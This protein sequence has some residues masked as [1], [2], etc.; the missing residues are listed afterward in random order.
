MKLRQKPAIVKG[1]VSTT[2]VQDPTKHLLRTA[3]FWVITQRI[4]AIP[5]RYIGTTCRSH[6]KGSGIQKKSKHLLLL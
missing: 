2:I 1:A 6:L 4:V 5:Y 3:L